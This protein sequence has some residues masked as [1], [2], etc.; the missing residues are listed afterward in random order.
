M[1]F[2]NNLFLAVYSLIQHV[3]LGPRLFF[4]RAKIYKPDVF[5]S[6]NFASPS[7]K[8]SNYLVQK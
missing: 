3:D 8:P 1:C 5:M 7:T 4:R 2:G 6:V